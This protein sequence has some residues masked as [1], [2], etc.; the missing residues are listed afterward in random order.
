MLQLI[1]AQLVEL[2]LSQLDDVFRR[3]LATH[4]QV[5]DPVT[6]LNSGT[7]MST[8]NSFRY[9][10]SRPPA[11]TSTTSFHAHRFLHLNTKPRNPIRTN[12]RRNPR[13][14]R[15][16]LPLLPLHL[17]PLPTPIPSPN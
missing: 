9:S 3:T 8:I 7:N 4:S 17:S 10:I 2:G 13:N 5:I 15:L 12:L 16:L 14:L 1:K 11:S 6:F